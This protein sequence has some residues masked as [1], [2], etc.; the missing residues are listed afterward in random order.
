MNQSMWTRATFALFAFSMLAPFAVRADQQADD[1]YQQY[2][3]ATAKGQYEMAA[4]LL[5]KAAN[6]DQAKYGKEC[7]N[8]QAFV[9]NRLQRYDS[10]FVTGK[11]E[12]EIKDYVGAIRDLSKIDFG[13]HRE[14]AQ[15]L[16]AQAND[17]INHPQPVDTNPQALKAAQLAYE[18]GDFATA[19]AN[20][21][22]VKSAE[23]L[24]QAQVILSNIRAYNNNMQQGDA[25]LASKNY[26][27]AQ[28]RYNAALAIKSN[29]PGN[30]SGK[31]QQIATLSKGTQQPGNK[32][33]PQ[34]NA[35]R[36]QAGLSE[37]QAAAAKGN[38][39]AALAAYGR[40]LDL[41][42]KQPEALAGRTQA[43]AALTKDPQALEDTLVSGVRAYYESHFPEA[44]E[45]ISL[46]LTA[47]GTRNKGAAY[48][49][50]GATMISQAF[51]ADP[52]K[53][54]NSDRLRQSALQQFQQAKQEKYKP[55]EKYVS[56]KVLAV[57]NQAGM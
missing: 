12:F 29:G 57:W 24:P 22:Q 46:Y 19:E 42:P 4:A 32:P 3:A 25:F 5:C 56:P 1:L 41:D 16:I 52:K 51:V 40:V 6:I 7:A 50:L 48:F 47:G 36:I 15:K 30:P 10:F 14:E 33:N 35:Q 31:L 49:Y 13:P 11:S 38:W 45:A 27:A 54:D 20:A 39:Q 8:A 34:D 9:N 23:L 44:R 17:F 28:Q 18:N 21:A 53:P 2:K 37:A 55:V 26:S 43:Q